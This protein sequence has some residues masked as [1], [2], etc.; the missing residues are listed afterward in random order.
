MAQF[1]QTFYT[2]DLPSEYLYNKYFNNSNSFKMHNQGHKIDAEHIKAELLSGLRGHLKTF[3]PNGKIKGNSFYIGNIH[4]DKGESLVITLS[5]RYAGKGKDF[6]TGESFDIFALFA[7]HFNLDT[8]TQ[9][10]QLLQ[11][12]SEYL[13]SSQSENK[14]LSQAEIIS[15]RERQEQAKQRQIEAEKQKQLEKQAK[16]DKALELWN[17]GLCINEATT[18]AYLRARG[19]DIQFNMHVMRYLPEAWH[20]ELKMNLPCLIALVTE[21]KG[22]PYILNNGKHLIGQ[23]GQPIL[24]YKEIGIERHYLPPEP[25]ITPEAYKKWFKDKGITRRMMLGSKKGGVIKLNDSYKDKLVLCEGLFDALTLLFHGKELD[26]LSDTETPNV[27][28]FLGIN[29]LTDIIIEP[30]Y[31]EI[32]LLA[33]NDS[34]GLNS[35]E[36]LKNNHSLKGRT[37]V[38]IE[39]F[40]TN[41]HK[42]LNELWLSKLREKPERSDPNELNKRRNQESLESLLETFN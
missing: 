40:K 19:L 35:I 39:I 24:A 33:D 30:M 20:R 27:Y 36:L 9:F 2:K 41:S 22:T 10:Y 37:D 18:Q 5:G 38:K 31:Q 23:N 11:R 12:L 29:N 17:S 26:I 7:H 25:Q 21:T 16:T 8:K 34:A 42:D 1:G 14:Q 28:A 6:A 3:Y 32:Y 4:G 13:G 15:I